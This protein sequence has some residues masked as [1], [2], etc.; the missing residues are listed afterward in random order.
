MT[1]LFSVSV[2]DQVVLIKTA[3]LKKTRENHYALPDTSVKQCCSNIYNY[4]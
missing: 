3:I 4:T 2:T 1:G